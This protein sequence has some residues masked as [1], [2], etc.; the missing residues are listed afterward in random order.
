MSGMVNPRPYIAPLREREPQPSTEP[1]TKGTVSEQL[2]KLGENDSGPVKIDEHG[3]VT[4]G[5]FGMKMRSGLNAFGFGKPIDDIV[6]NRKTLN[7]VMQLLYEEARD[8]M[9]EQNKKWAEEGHKNWQ[10]NPDT[11]AQKVMD[12]L[13][14]SKTNLYGDSK[15]LGKTDPGYTI[16]QR[17]DRG[18]YLSG[19]LAGQLKMRFDDI[20]RGSIEK[21]TGN[22]IIKDEKWKQARIDEANRRGENLERLG[23]TNRDSVSRF[24][25]QEVKNEGVIS[26]VVN[27]V[28]GLVDGAQGLV[29]RLTG[30][31]TR[32]TAFERTLLQ[33]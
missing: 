23:P 1:Q 31:E 3:R 2:G 32:N 22:L 11:Y 27:T 16:E 28:A 6:S 33:I 25:G 5:S 12:A 29:D 15:F 19:E 24:L 8:T 20:L 26:T 4:E 17:I 9:I 7:N 14:Q 13:Y 10:F 30:T 18:T 21:T